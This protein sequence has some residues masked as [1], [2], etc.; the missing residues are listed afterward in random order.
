MG[1]LVAP[2]WLQT[3]AEESKEYKHYLIL[4]CVGRRSSPTDLPT[5]ITARTQKA[6]GL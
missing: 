5:K 3:I 2:W 1:N 4:Y 6:S